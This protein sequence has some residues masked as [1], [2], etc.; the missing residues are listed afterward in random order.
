MSHSHCTLLFACIVQLTAPSPHA[1][2]ASISQSTRKKEYVILYYLLFFT[3]FSFMLGQTNVLVLLNGHIKVCTFYHKSGISPIWNIIDGV[4][5]KNLKHVGWNWSVLK[6]D[7]HVGA[8]LASVKNCLLL[9][10][11]S[12]IKLTK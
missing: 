4:L 1:I 6:I 3:M 12:S 2:S 7:P 5:F 9:V 8:I 10:F 11:L